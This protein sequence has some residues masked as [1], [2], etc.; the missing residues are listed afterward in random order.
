MEGELPTSNEEKINVGGDVER[1]AEGKRKDGN[2]GP[3]LSKAERK[4]LKLQKRDIQKES[5]II[6][7]MKE[8]EY[9]VHDGTELFDYIGGLY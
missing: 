4:K 1:K 7:R 5:I 3:S 6:E 9:E 8:T 2:R